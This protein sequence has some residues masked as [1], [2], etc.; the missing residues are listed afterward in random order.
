MPTLAVGMRETSRN[1]DM[2]TIHR[3]GGFRFFFYAGDR[4]E[5]PHVHVERGEG[6]A[7][8]WLNPVRFGKQQ[9]IQAAR[10]ERYRRNRCRKRA[11][12]LAGM[13]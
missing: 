10:I 2:P 1:Q 12:I 6:I 7:K 3:A 9:G 8:Y 5:P 13:E 4:S 11:E